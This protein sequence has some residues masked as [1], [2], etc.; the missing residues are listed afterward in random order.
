MIKTLS[1][2]IILTCSSA[3]A[4]AREPAEVPP[5][6]EVIL[7][8]KARVVVPKGLQVK[9]ELGVMS[10]ES[11]E[12]FLARRLMEI[13]NLLSKTE[14]AS[15]QLKTGLKQLQ[16]DLAE[17][18]TDEIKQVQDMLIDTEVEKRR[19][20]E[21]LDQLKT[22]LADINLSNIQKLKA[23]LEEAEIDNRII[24]SEVERSKKDLEKIDELEDRLIRVETKM[25]K[26]YELLQT[27]IR[28]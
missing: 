17:L 21:D 23:R 11:T 4:E 27:M 20:R 6:M 24:K 7:V 28:R 1:L 9:K 13:D 5:G 15:A 12:E 22:S 16:E 2:I 19:L 18:Q 10:I 3:L 8:G 25:D 26:V 14:T